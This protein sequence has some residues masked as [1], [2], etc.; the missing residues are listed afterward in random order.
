[1]EPKMS[2]LSRPRISVIGL[3]KLGAPMAA[4]FACKGF[5][6]IGLDVNSRFVEAINDG[7]APVEEPRLQEMIDSGRSRLRATKSFE[8]AVLNSDVSFI[9]VPTPSGTDRFF[10]NRFVIDAVERIGAA[11]RSKKQ[12]HVV[13]VTSTVMPGATNGEIR[14]ALE[15][16]AGR[17]VGSDLG[18]CYN[19]EFIALGSV[20]HDLLYPDIIL[21][22]AS[23]EKAGD[24]LEVIYRVSTD[25]NPEFHR[26]NLVN[27]E[28]T[29]ISINTYVTTKIS[30]A[31]MIADMCDH[32]PDAD[33]DV[34]ARAVGGDSRIGRKYLKGAIGYGGPCFPRDNK[35]FAAL[36]RKLGVNTELAEATDKINEHQLARLTGAVEALAQR[37]STI[38]L[39]GMSYKPDTA[40]IEESQGVMLARILAKQGYKVIVS[41]PLATQAAASVIGTAAEAMSDAAAAVRE[42][43]LVVVMTPWPQFKSIPSEA[44]RRGSGA[45]T[46]IDPWRVVDAGSSGANVVHL[47]SGEWK[48]AARRTMAA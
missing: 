37:G 10:S 45:V 14:A 9:I 48:S 26:M 1:M 8:V 43:D 46:V 33:A 5:E 13:V 7:R 3:G 15:L 30:Y 28:L 25:T 21:I 39:L 6:T 36:G 2:E 31:N 34:V 23:D 40:V 42:A 19:P 18:L 41:D 24:V 47:G 12:Y 38:T 35:A 17:E 32:L 29:K 20:V 27:A 16:A 4:V 44:F 22:G 11:L